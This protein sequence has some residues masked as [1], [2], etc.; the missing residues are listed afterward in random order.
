MTFK[1]RDDDPKEAAKKVPEKGLWIN[2][3]NIIL[4]FLSKESYLLR[5]NLFRS[6]YKEYFK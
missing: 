3:N 2:L 1:S 6:F 4:Y 5:Y